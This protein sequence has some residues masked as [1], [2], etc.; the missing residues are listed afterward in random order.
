MSRNLLLSSEN[1]YMGYNTLQDTYEVSS[2]RDLHDNPN[3]DKNTIEFDSDVWR[4]EKED[5]LQHIK[6]KIDNYEKRYKTQVTEIAMAGTVG[7]WHGNPVGGKLVPANRLEEIFNM[8]V[9]T[10][11]VYALDNNEI[12]IEGC[13]HDGTHHMNLHLL[14]DNKKKHLSHNE[15]EMYEQLVQ[16]TGLKF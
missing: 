2:Y 5:F 9:D 11:E 7:L 15:I 10:I 6:S 1:C 4:T 3:I 12:E 13:H 14:T 16:K 8:D